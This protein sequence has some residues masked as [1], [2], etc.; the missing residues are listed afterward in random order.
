M[1]LVAT[2]ALG[3]IGVDNAVEVSVNVNCAPASDCY[4]AAFTDASGGFVAAAANEDDEETMDEDES[5]VTVAVACDGYARS[6]EL[7][8]D[9]EGMVSAHFG[10]ENLACSDGTGTAVIEGIKAGGWYWV[11]DETSSAVSALL[12]LSVYGNSPTMPTM[13]GGI[14]VAESPGFTVQGVEYES[15]ATFV[16]HGPS[17]RVG[18]LSHLLPQPPMARCAGTVLNDCVLDAKYS[19]EATLPD[20]DDTDTDPDGV[21]DG[22][23]VDRAADAPVVMTLSLVGDGHL[24]VGDG[25]L[26]V[27]WTTNGVAD[28]TKEVDTPGVAE[29]SGTTIDIAT[30]ANGRCAANNP[31][32]DAKVGVYVTATPPETGFGAVPV[33]MPV[34]FAFWVACPELEAEAAT[35][36]QELVPDNPFP[37]DR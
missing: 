31:D 37:T 15:V 12:P 10:D 17:G 9:D 1:A 21:A 16:K 20:G 11:N 3:Q 2:A 27:T 5:L 26:T 23:S 19:I 7:T 25:T 30:E 34:Q 36:G 6:G 13:P 4:I 24:P 18:I 32:R 28:S 14:L 33:P 8:P 35:Q 29:V 22:G